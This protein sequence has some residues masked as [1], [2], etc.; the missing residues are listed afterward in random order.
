M[1]TV[2][3]RTNP[4][5]GTE[6][7]RKRWTEKERAELATLEA[8]QQ[9]R[10]AQGLSVRSV[11]NLLKEADKEVKALEYAAAYRTLQSAEELGVLRD[12]VGLAMMEIAF[13]T[14]ETVNWQGRK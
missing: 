1:A 8:N 7:Q 3:R 11:F 12:S 14:L 4:V 13:Y 10:N 5:C 9:Q 6:K 2:S